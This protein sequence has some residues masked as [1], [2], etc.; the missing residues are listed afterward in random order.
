MTACNCK[1]PYFV[2]SYPTLPAQEG[3]LGLQGSKQSD[4]TEAVKYWLSFM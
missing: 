1:L 2:A 3:A 4:K